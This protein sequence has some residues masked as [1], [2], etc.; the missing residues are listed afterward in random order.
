MIQT[1]KSGLTTGDLAHAMQS[2]MTAISCSEIGAAAW[3]EK[4]LRQL[5]LEII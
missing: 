1:E 3:C 5:S 2:P 4:S